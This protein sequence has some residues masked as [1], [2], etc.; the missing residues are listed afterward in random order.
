MKKTTDQKPEFT[1]DAL[2]EAIRTYSREDV[3][4]LLQKGILKEIT[5]SLYHCKAWI[6]FQRL[7]DRKTILI[8]RFFLSSL[9]H[10][11][12]NPLLASASQ[13]FT[14]VFSMMTAKSVIPCSPF[15]CSVA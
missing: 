7:P 15:P 12:G 14:N 4:Y 9:R 2:S 11:N 1:L 6:L 13:N 8:Q 3:S 10:P 5:A